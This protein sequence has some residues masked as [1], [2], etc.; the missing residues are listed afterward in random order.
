MIS[1]RNC[2]VNISIFFLFFPDFFSSLSLFFFLHSLHHPR[3]IIFY[4]PSIFQKLLDRSLFILQQFLGFEMNFSTISSL[5]RGEIKWLPVPTGRISYHHGDKTRFF[6]LFRVDLFARQ[7]IPS[8]GKEK[9]KKKKETAKSL[10]T[11]GSLTFHVVAVR[12]LVGDN[13]NFSAAGQR[14]GRGYCMDSEPLYLRAKW[15]N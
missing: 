8:P 14:G 11:L 13:K 3:Y 6:D 7:T 4:T 9:K 2:L 15:L 10:Y 12:N 1:S 5:I